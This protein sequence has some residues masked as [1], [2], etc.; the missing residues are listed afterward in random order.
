MNA[1]RLRC[2]ILGCGN[3]LRGDD[4]VGA[5][6]CAWADERFA[7]KP[8][9]RV[10][11]RQQ[12]TPELA[13]DV[14]AADSVIFIDCSIEQQ[15][16]QI[17]LREIAPSTSATPGTHHVGATELLALARELFESTPRRA[18]L[19]TIGAGSLELGERFSPAVKA[20]LPDAQALLELTVRQVLR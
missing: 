2:L 13:Q 5:F 7:G 12:W 1:P 20:A 6:L 16:G 17:H 4:G 14:A 3:T 18:C 11:A 9:V 10:I 8:G 19:L 15:P